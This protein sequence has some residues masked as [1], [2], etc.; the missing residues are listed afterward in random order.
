MP[1]YPI[2]DKAGVL[3]ASSY[4]RDCNCYN[5]L[6]SNMDSLH[7]AFVH[8][9][10]AFTTPASTGRCPKSRARKPIT[11]SSNTAPAPTARR[12]QSPFFWPNV[13]YIRSS[14]EEG[15]PD[16]WADHIAWRV[17]I[18]DEHHCSFMVNHV[19][20]IGEDASVIASAK[21][22]RRARRGSA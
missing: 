3:T 16:V 10:S 9:S 17:P 18:D 15:D 13:L 8:R 19:A 2:F 1:R 11:A 5:N 14:P 12:A 6:E 20:L 7:T 21:R 22:Q 4:I